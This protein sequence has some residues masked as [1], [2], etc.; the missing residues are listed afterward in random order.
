M[1]ARLGLIQGLATDRTGIGSLVSEAVTTCAVHAYRMAMKLSRQLKDS[2]SGYKSSNRPACCYQGLTR[3]LGTAFVNIAGKILLHFD[4]PVT[5]NRTGCERA[6]R[7]GG[8][9]VAKR[10]NGYTV[11]QQDTRDE[12]VEERRATD[13]DEVSEKL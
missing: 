12:K 3:Q 5:V 8:R 9:T 2:R 6:R 1:S 13:H 7:G 4:Q 10:R 11:A